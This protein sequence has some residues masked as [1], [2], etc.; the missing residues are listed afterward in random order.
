M[1]GRGEERRQGMEGIEVEGGGSDDPE[2]GSE[3]CMYVHNLCSG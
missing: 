1:Y 2:R 3:E